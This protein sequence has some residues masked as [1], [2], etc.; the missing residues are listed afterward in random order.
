MYVKIIT[1][2]LENESVRYN[3]DTREKSRNLSEIIKK[4]NVLENGLEDSGRLVEILEVT[5]DVI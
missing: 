4:I 1:I 5:R 2:R 3:L